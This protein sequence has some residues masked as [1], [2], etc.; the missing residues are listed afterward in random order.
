MGCLPSS[1]SQPICLLRAAFL[2]YLLLRL[3]EPKPSS[4]SRKHKLCAEVTHLVSDQ[5]ESKLLPHT[6]IAGSPPEGQCPPHPGCA[7]YPASEASLHYG[8]LPYSRPLSVI[9]ATR[10]GLAP[11]VPGIDRS[12]SPTNV[13]SRGLAPAF[14][15]DAPWV[16]EDRAG[17]GVLN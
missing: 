8:L 3:L 1:S 2:H 13:E 11:R 5:P 7:W 6:H 16:N 4:Q 15:L 14:I 17:S 9:L 10:A 12:S